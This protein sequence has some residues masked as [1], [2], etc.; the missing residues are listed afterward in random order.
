MLQ[1]Y[2]AKIKQAIINKN[3]TGSVPFHGKGFELLGHCSRVFDLIN[4]QV[5]IILQTSE[6]TTLQYTMW[7]HVSL[8]KKLSH[9]SNVVLFPSKMFVLS[10]R[11]LLLPPMPY[12]MFGQVFTCTPLNKFPLTNKTTNISLMGID[13]TYQPNNAWKGENTF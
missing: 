13:L 6:I 3:K 1:L 9:E 12:F 4:I 2:N 11:F 8:K 5:L 7:K 10:F